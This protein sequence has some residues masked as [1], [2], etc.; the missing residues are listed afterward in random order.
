MT[1]EPQDNKNEDS[2]CDQKDVEEDAAER[3]RRIRREAQIMSEA[4]LNKEVRDH[5]IRASSEMLLAMDAMLPREKI[6]LR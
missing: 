6:L 1:E 5:L 3:T 2:D 4:V